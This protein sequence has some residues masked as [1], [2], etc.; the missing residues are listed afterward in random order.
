MRTKEELEITHQAFERFS[1]RL[2]QDH[3]AVLQPDVDT[4]F[5]DHAD[6]ARRLL[7]FHIYQQPRDDLEL[8]KRH[9]G[10]QK[11]TNADH[12]EEIKDTRFALACHERYQ[13]LRNRFRNARIR[14]ATRSAPADQAYVLAQAILEADRVDVSLLSNELK[15]ARTELE[16]LE[17]EKRAPGATATRTV[18]ATA[19]AMAAAQAQYYRTYPYAYTQ[20]YGAPMPPPTTTTFHVSPPPPTT[21]PNRPNTAIPVQLPV[22]SLPALHALGIHPVPASSIVEGSDQTPPA[23]LRGSTANGTMLTLEINV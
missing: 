2:A 5:T 13:K 3:I 16:R 7:P 20:A 23:V 22:A 17:R 1:A 18:Y 8:L 15:V 10:K 14:T 4:P 11:I 21:N 9:K 19:P 6:A 12:Q